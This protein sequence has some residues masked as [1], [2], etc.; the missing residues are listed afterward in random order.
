VPQAAIR[1]YEK[2]A[3]S[4]KEIRKT[5]SEAGLSED[6]ILD[7]WYSADED[8]I[9]INGGDWIDNDLLDQWKDN[10]EGCCSSLSVTDEAGGPD[11]GFVSVYR[12]PVIGKNAFLKRAYSPNLRRVGQALQMF[13]SEVSKHIPGSP[14]PIASM[15]AGGLLGAGLGYGGGWVGEQLFPKKWKRGRLRRAM[16]MLGGLAGAVPGGIWGFTNRS[17]GRGFNDPS[18]LNMP[19]EPNVP[20]NVMETRPNPYADID[21]GLDVELQREVIPEPLKAASALPQGFQFESWPAQPSQSYIPVEEVTHTTMYD[22]RVAQRLS[23]PVQAVTN[24]VVQ[25]ASHL[26]GGTRFITPMDMGRIT[27][28]MGSGYLSGLIVGK[29]L[30]ALTGM[31]ETTQSRLKSTGMWAGMLAN[32]A[33]LM[34]PRT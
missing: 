24:S 4:A 31:P 18:L 6:G 15:V 3:S 23:A 13:P 19:P 7:V 5:I 28:G 12:R 14:S 8:E 2:T 16:M 29:V 30:S 33:P 26:G 34:F 1:L 20:K 25:G 22:P 9:R 27:A 10:L 21:S 32:T 11:S 17:I